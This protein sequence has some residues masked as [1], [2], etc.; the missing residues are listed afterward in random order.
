MRDAWLRVTAMS[1]TVGK[2]VI[3]V[4]VCLFWYTVITAMPFCG[5]MAPSVSPSIS[6]GC[7]SPFLSGGSSPSTVD[8]I[9]SPRSRW[10][11]ALMLSGGALRIGAVRMRGVL[12]GDQHG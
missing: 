7:V 4:G 8:T 6:M 12:A 3:L 11:L 5:I 9:L 1:A 10:P 2:L